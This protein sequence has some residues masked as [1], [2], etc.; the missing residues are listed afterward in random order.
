MTSTEQLNDDALVE[1]WRP[2][3]EAEYARDQRNVARQPFGEYW[4]WVKTY[5]LDG[6]SGYPGWL[7]QSATLLAQVRDSAARARLAPLLHDTG[8]RIA[9]EWA[10]DS[11]CRTIY[12]TFLQ[13]RPNLMEWGRTLQ[14]AAGRDT[15][16]GRQIEA[17]AL[18]IKAELDALSR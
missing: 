16:D 3:F 11:A 7:P 2:Y 9:G 12:S 5:L 14:R 13:G 15:G 4:R 10:K 18:S 17:A 8:R 6:G 1:S